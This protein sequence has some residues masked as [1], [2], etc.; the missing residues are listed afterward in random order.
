M[1]IPTNKRTGV[2]YPAISDQEKQFYE[3]DPALKGKYTFKRQVEKMP[4]EVA[5]PVEAKKTKETEP[6]V[7]A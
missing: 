4:K 1:W 5:E 6:L 3:T 7:K 2:I